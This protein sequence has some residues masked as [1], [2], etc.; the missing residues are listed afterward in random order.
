MPTSL[1]SRIYI[2]IANNY[3]CV[4][5]KDDAIKWYEKAYKNSTND[6]ELQKMIKEVMKELR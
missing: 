2:D 3:N 1:E 5:H 6:G 4:G